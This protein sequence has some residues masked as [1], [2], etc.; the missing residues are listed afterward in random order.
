[1]LETDFTPIPVPRLGETPPDL[2]AEA[3][4]ARSRGYAD[5]YAQGLRSATERGELQLSAER[6]RMQRTHAA[7]L[8]EQ[9]DALT[10]VR[11]AQDALEERIALLSDV[12]AQRIEALAV[13]LARAILGAELS[14]PAR[15]AA[16]ALRRALA[17]MPISRWVRVT[18]DEADARMLENA[19]DASATLRGIEVVAA[20][21]LGAGGAIVE[22]DA[23]AVDTRIA[24][25]LARAVAA[26][27]GEDDDAPRVGAP[28]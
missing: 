20:P 13:E 11:T 16:H 24:E 18:F 4:R 22:I 2:A 5:G 17:H 14:D 19:P 21:G 23:G 6:E 12:S 25:A 7:G 27:D 1:M 15:S 8:R 26:V 9:A 28:S 10:A 3:E